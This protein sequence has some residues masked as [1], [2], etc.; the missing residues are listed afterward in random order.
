M[1]LPDA[2]GDELGILRAEVQ[3]E[4]KLRR[5]HAVPAD[6]SAARGIVGQD[7]L[8][9]VLGGQRHGCPHPKSTSEEFVFTKSC[10]S[11]FTAFDGPL[12]C[13]TF[14]WF[15]TFVEN[16]NVPVGKQFLHCFLIGQDE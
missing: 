15:Y 12:I 8:V 5:R 16:R 4:D 7:R 2:P 14:L 11:M 13:P 1:T 6:G 9:L 10:I 3:D